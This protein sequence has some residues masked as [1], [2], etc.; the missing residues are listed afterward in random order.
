LIFYEIHPL[1]PPPLAKEGEEKERRDESPSPQAIPPGG[2]IK[3]LSISLYERETKR[4]FP[5]FSKGD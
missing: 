2:E 3:S 5:P 4:A 1:Y